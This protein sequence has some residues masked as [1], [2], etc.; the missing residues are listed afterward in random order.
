MKYTKAG[1]GEYLILV[2]GA[3]TDET[4]WVPHI[5]YLK[6][7]YEVIAITLRHFGDKEEGGFGLNTHADDLASFLEDLGKEKPINIVGWSYGADVILN[8]LTRHTVDL[9]GIFL[10][11]PGF[12][13]CLSEQDMNAWL[14]DA[15][16]IFGKVYEYFSQGQARL[17]VEALVDGSGNRQGYFMNQPDMVRELQLAKADTLA[18]QLNQQEQPDISSDSISR[19]R[20]PFAVGYGSETRDMFRLVSIKTA[21]SS[22]TAV[23]VRVDG[24]GHMLPQEK[25]EK[26]SSLI[27]TSLA[28]PGHTG[29]EGNISFT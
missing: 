4:M 7:D 25:P 28:S 29:E 17:A 6:S 24:E 13:G 8:M 12:P 15:N 21:E 10:Y 20:V 9:K 18:F 26:F 27:K 14:S 16:A 11:E 19:I 2:H 22:E 23:L 3:L 5:E 1:S